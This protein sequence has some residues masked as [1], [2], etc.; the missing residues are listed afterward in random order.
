MDNDISQTISALINNRPVRW[1]DY[2]IGGYDGHEQTLEVFDADATEQLTLLRKIRQVNA[3][4]IVIFHTRSESKRLYNDFLQAWNN[5]K[6]WTDQKVEIGES[7]L[8][9]KETII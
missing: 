2:T 9:R 1:A 8:H 5:R 3:S 6:R 4:L 7:K